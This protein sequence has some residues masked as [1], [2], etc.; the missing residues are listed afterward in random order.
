MPVIK[1]P[2]AS[3]AYD[4]VGSGPTVI[5]GHSLFCTRSMW[6]GAVAGAGH[7]TTV[8]QP[9]VV[10]GLLRSFFAGCTAEYHP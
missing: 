8:E 3:V 1:R 2:E 10:A 7:L 4:L 6:D 5:L 9:R